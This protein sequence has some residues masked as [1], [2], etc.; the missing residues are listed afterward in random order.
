MQEGVNTIKFKLFILQRVKSWSQFRFNLSSGILFAIIS[1][2]ISIFLARFIII[3]IGIELYGLWLLIA[4]VMFV[5]NIGY[6]CIGDAIV[7]HVA[8]AHAKDN[9]ELIQ[10]YFSSGNAIVSV[11]GVVVILVLFFFNKLIIAFI[12]IPKHLS[13]I[14]SDLF[15]GM[16]F[17][18]LLFLIIVIINGTLSGIGRIDLTNYNRTI[19]RCVQF[20]VTMVLLKIKFGIWSV[21]WG[22]AMFQI[23]CLATGIILI[24]KLTYIRLLTLRGINK[25]HAVDLLRMSYKLVLGRLVVLGTDPLLKL[26]LGRYIGLQAVVFFEIGVKVIRLMALPAIT[27]FRAVVPRISRVDIKA[28]TGVEDMIRVNKIMSKY[29]VYAGFPVF[30][31]VF[32][33]SGYILRMW[34]GSG[35][36][37][38]M[39]YSLQILSIPYFLHLLA[40]PK[41]NTLIGLGKTGYYVAAAIV[42]TVIFIAGLSINMAMG[43]KFGFHGAIIA[44]GAG[45][46]AGSLFI[47]VSYSMIVKTAAKNAT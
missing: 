3:E 30:L 38:N 40:N 15:V 18:L 7:R 42:I 11:A 33:G 47:L 20:I 10:S 41:L 13:A 39:Q 31:G 44:Y 1:T 28:K 21:F 23:I 17:L 46:L 45:I 14:A 4:T 25:R 29:I 32:L 36:D 12:K 19:G 8:M 35:F 16:G 6:E 43:F 9:K 22:Q 27:A 34:L 24:K 26:V 2:I 5:G 37:I